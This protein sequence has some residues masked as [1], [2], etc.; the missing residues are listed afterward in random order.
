MKLLFYTLEH[1]ISGFVCLVGWFGL[2]LLLVKP[3]LSPWC[4]VLG[5]PLTVALQHL[6][7]L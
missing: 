7:L 4:E 2:I 3:F 6:Q 1:G 5:F